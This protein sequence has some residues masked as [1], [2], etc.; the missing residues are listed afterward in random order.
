MFS[1]R[2]RSLVSG[3]LGPVAEYYRSCGRFAVH[4]AVCRA[5]SLRYGAMFSGRGVAVRPCS[6]LGHEFSVSVRGYCL[7]EIEVRDIKSC[8]LP[9]LRSAWRVVLFHLGLIH[10]GGCSRLGVVG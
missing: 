2:A 8:G 3:R 5:P 9:S 7:W 1:V 6:V 4:G 10:R